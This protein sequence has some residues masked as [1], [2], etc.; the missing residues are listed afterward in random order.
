MGIIPLYT[1]EQRER[2][3]EKETQREAENLVTG[4]R[5]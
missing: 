1:K 2:E 4:D 3:R 5:I